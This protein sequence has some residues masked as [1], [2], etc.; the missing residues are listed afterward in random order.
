MSYW[1][2]TLKM[3]GK[4]REEPAT[5]VGMSRLSRI[6]DKSWAP[7]LKHPISTIRIRLRRE[8]SCLKTYPPST[9]NMRR[10]AGVTGTPS[11]LP[12]QLP[13]LFPDWCLDDPRGQSL[14]LA[15]LPG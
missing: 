14:T 8:G 6:A 5:R 1:N 4:F 10:D 15:I 9:R 11:S 3:L 13:P 7:S 12:V 2:E